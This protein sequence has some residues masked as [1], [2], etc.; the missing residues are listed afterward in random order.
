MTA[1]ESNPAKVKAGAECAYWRRENRRVKCTAASR[2]LLFFFFF[3]F[4]FLSGISS[5]TPERHKKYAHAQQRN[6]AQV[7]DVEWS[8]ADVATGE[9]GEV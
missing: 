9:E 8:L 6:K 2:L 3:F 4:F 5:Q 1:F 7:H